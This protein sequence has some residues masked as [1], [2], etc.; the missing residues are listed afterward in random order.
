MFYNLFKQAMENGYEWQ[1]VIGITI[2]AFSWLGLSWLRRYLNR[3]ERKKEARENILKA[4]QKLDDDG[5]ANF[6]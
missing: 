2:F 3:I 5:G 1:S 4:L 6:S